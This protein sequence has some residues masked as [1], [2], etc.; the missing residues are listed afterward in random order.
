ML[1]R[2]L[3]LIDFEPNELKNTLLI[4]MGCTAKRSHLLD[5]RVGE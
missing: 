1:I 2:D 4:G 3:G 5:Q